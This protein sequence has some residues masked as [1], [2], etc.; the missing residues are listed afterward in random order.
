MVLAYFRL[1]HCF[2]N[3]A[4][5]LSLHS[6]LEP[7]TPTSL[8]QP[9]NFV[10]TSQFIQNEVDLESQSMQPFQVDLFGPSLNI[11]FIYVSG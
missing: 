7:Q 9:L 5:S 1:S 10:L 11:I 4:C 6:S 2:E 8:W 3:I